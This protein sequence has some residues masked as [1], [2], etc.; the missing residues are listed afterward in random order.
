MEVSLNSDIDIRRVQSKK[1]LLSFIKLQWKIN[2]NDP[3]WVAPLLMDRLKVLNKKSNPFFKDNPADFFLAYRNGE[4]VGRIAAIINHQHNKFHEDKT[5]FFGF[6]EAQNDKEIFN[7]LLNT[8]EDWLRE[9]N[10]DLMMGPMNPSTN[11]EVGFLIDGYDTPPFFMMTHN[12]PY[13]NDFMQD[14]GFEK[15][16]DLFA[17]FIHKDN[18]NMERV[19]QLSE[20]MKKRFSVSIRNLNMKNFESELKTVREIYNDA[21]SKNWGFVPMTPEEFDFIANDFKKIIDPELVMIAEYK[22]RPIGFSLALPNY[23][24]IFKKIP[25]GKLFPFGIFTFL[26]NKN[27]IRSIRA[28]TLGVTKD[29]QTSGIGGMLILETIRRGLS[30]GYVSAEMS[31]VLED[32][33]LMNKGASLVGGK[34]YKTYRVYQKAI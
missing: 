6:L 9:K 22:G 25:S 21:W 15:A 16:K 29:Y 20:S 5:G 32:N 34:I 3:N 23:N 24:E 30:A 12:P 1:D 17:Y 27:K 7:S 2:E 28:I 10:C 33:D 18:L 13:Y 8:A 4:V 19:N 14:L 11:D 31:W 26:L